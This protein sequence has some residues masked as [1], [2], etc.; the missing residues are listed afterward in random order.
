MGLRSAAGLPEEGHFWRTARHFHSSVVPGWPLL[1]SWQRQREI[2][3]IYLVQADGSS[4]H[5]ERLLKT[6]AVVFPHSYSKEAKRLAYCGLGTGRGGPSAGIFTVPLAEENGQWKAGKAEP[7][8]PPSPF[9]DQTPAFSPD[10]RWLAYATNESGQSEVNVRP[11]SSP[12]RKLPGSTDGGSNPRWWRNELLY[13]S[14]DRIMS[15]SYTVNGDTFIPAKPRVRVDKIGSTEWDVAPDGRILVLT[16][17]QAAE[18][19]EA[20][21]AEHTVVFLL[22]FFDELRRRVPLPK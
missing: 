20:P 8:L 3:G 13:Q 16:P 5:P 17:A 11:A 2:S 4:Q 18:A 6:E 9:I 21:P 19:T 1:V 7:F 12:S 10:G 22:N 14:G 15:V